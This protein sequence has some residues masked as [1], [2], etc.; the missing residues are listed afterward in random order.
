MS[1]A[2]YTARRT[3]STNEWDRTQTLIAAG[4]TAGVTSVAAKIAS[5]YGIDVVS[6]IGGKLRQ[7]AWSLGMAAGC[8]AAVAAVTRWLRAEP[9]LQWPPLQASERE[10][11]TA[12]MAEGI[13]VGGAE[14][15]LLSANCTRIQR[16]LPVEGVEYIVYGTRALVLES[17]PGLVFKTLERASDTEQH[18]DEILYAKKCIQEY[19][20]GCD[21]VVP[22]SCLIWVEAGNRRVPFI[23]QQRLDFDSTT[24]AQQE[25]YYSHGPE[26]SDG[27]RDLTRFVCQ[28]GR[29]AVSY[30]S[31]P[32]L[33][34]RNADG[35]I[36][37]ALLCPSHL[38]GFGGV[39][40]LIEITPECLWGKIY[41]AA[42]SYSEVEAD[43]FLD[44]T[45]YTR[46]GRLADY[47]EIVR[48]YERKGLE[49]GLEPI[50]VEDPSDLGLDLD[51]VQEIDLEGTFW[52]AERLGVQPGEK[53]RA[54]KGELLT[55]ILNEINE[56]IAAGADQ[57]TMRGKR[58]VYMRTK[59][60]KLQFY[61]DE[62]GRDGS[63]QLFVSD[64]EEERR[65]WVFQIL[66][67]LKEKGYIHNWW[68]ARCGLMVQA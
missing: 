49:T 17:A 6:I 25:L 34:D 33:R 19:S 14:L 13:V 41:R 16:R 67:A 22:Q 55:F 62:L 21:L 30:S 66:N 57:T 65:L 2:S 1:A 9:E 68:R 64:A 50:V 12:E 5:D 56:G 42:R 43:V 59:T 4:L 58:R 52:S 38:I 23:V 3:T 48:F 54:V 60:G 32:I 20:F 26:L 51:E 47:H 28:F 18:F 44:A 29:T 36:Q 7:R 53:L 45:L 8:V 37:I 61:F 27:I 11:L 24:F 40:S 15:D 35:R 31:M 63:Q 10:R 46:G 39:Q